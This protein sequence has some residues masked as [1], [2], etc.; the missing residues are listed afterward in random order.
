MSSKKASG[1]TRQHSRP[2]GKR[3]GIKVT[4][5]EII[6]PGQILVRQ[7]GTVVKPGK[8]VKSGR[9]HTLYATKPGVAKFEQRRSR[10]IISVNG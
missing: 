6:V 8:F 10:K 7:R 3:L 2:K 1:A 4:D 9:D 5:G